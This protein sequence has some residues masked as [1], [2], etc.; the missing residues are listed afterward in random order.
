[1]VLT[2]D[3]NFST[4]IVKPRNTE[5]SVRLGEQNVYTFVVRQ[6]ATKRDV[7]AAITALY[8]VTPVNVNIV[9][10]TPRQYKSKAKNRR[11]TAKGMKKAYVYLKKGDTISLV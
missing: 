4:I 11:L 10:K 6:N 7:K 8:N 9:N 5:K 3:V 2:T 1:M